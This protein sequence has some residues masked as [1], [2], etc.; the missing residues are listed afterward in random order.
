MGCRLLALILCCPLVANATAVDTLPDTLQ[1]LVAKRRIPANGISIVVREVGAEGPLL[2]INPEKSRNPA[3]TIKLL[4]TWL[5]LEELGPAYTWP[6][7]AYID[8]ELH[9][10]TLRGDLI[11]KGYGDPYFIT[12]RLWRFQ[13]ELRMRGLQ[14][15]D[16]D[17][18]IDNS[19]FADEYGDPG[20]FDG[21]GLRVYNVHPDAF[22]VNF[23]AVRFL[24]LPDKASGRVKVVADPMPANL[25]VENQLLLGR[26]FCGGHLN[27]IKIATDDPRD[28]DRII[29]SG[30]YRQDCAEYSLSRAVLTAPTY[31]YG[32]FRSLWEETGGRL[33]GDL[34]LGSLPAKLTAEDTLPVTTEEDPA[35]PFL[36]VKSPP[37]VDVISY[38]N[39][40]SN[41]VMARHVFLTLGVEAFE[42]PG[43]LQKS[44]DA[45]RLALESYGMEFPE[46]RFDNGS[47]LSR[48]T[49]IAAQSMAEVLETAARRPWFA[50]FASSLSLPGLDGTMRRRFKDEEIAGQMHLK[51]GRL[52]DVFA[53]AGYVHARSGRD[54]VVVVLQNYRN[55]AGGPGE[56]L[57]AELLRWVYEQ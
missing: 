17:L 14:E 26:G 23:Q 34:R 47:G 52:N 51:T 42:P 32:V 6:T 21:R 38:I 11:I 53:T 43:T 40:F 30:K 25:S 31:A 15:I 8:G 33:N 24:F 41:N 1:K 50:E 44:R 57:Q 54:Y 10:G 16:G 36:R 20:E 29:F 37:L 9:R 3:S 13:R 55:A 2:S 35:G 56:E 49:R 4:T 5:A 27:G 19:H 18:V 22:L 7:E 39:K 28:R 48:S 46:L 12:E 45:A